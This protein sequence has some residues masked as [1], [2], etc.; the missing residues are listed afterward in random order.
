MPAQDVSVSATFEEEGPS[1]DAITWVKSE[2]SQDH[3]SD[4][5]LTVSGPIDTAS[6]HDE[7]KEYTIKTNTNPMIV[8][9][10]K[11]L[12]KIDKGHLVSIGLNTSIASNAYDDR[13]NQKRWANTQIGVGTLTGDTWTAESTFDNIKSL[14][15]E[16]VTAGAWTSNATPDTAKAKEHGDFQDN[17]LID[18]TKQVKENE[19]D[20]LSL[21]IVTLTGREQIVKN[22]PTL[23]IVTGQKVDFTVKSSAEDATPIEGA[24]IEIKTKDNP[25]TVATLTTAGGGN[26]STA[27][28]AGS[29]TYTV[30]S[31][32]YAIKKD[33]VLEIDSTDKTEEVELD[34]NQA[35]SVTIAPASGIT[36]GKGG[37]QKFTATVKDQDERDLSGAEL[38][39]T[40][41]RADE[42][43]EDVKITPDGDYTAT[44]AVEES[45]THDPDGEY[46]VTATVT[47]TEDVSGTATF[48]VNTKEPATVKVKYTSSDSKVTKAEETI[49][50]LFAGDEFT[51]DKKYY[52]A[53][54]KVSNEDGT[55]SV[56]KFNPEEQN[57][58]TI[59]ELSAG[60]NE[61]TLTYILDSKQYY[62][63]EDYEDA[64]TATL[65]TDKQ[66]L[67]TSIVD[68]EKLNSKVQLFTSTD[69]AANERGHAVF[70]FS[71][72]I[73]NEKVV[74]EYDMLFTSAD[75]KVTL[76]DLT[77]RA[78]SGKT[79]SQG[80]TTW[81]QA[82]YLTDGAIFE[83]G[84]YRDGRQSSSDLKS[85]WFEINTAAP[86]P[87][88]RQT[89]WLHVKATIDTTEKKVEYSI[90]KT[91]D[92]DKTE[93]YGTVKDNDSTPSNYMITGEKEATKFD[94]I[95]V[96]TVS[97]SAKF[98][99]DNLM[100][101][102]AD[103]E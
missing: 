97:N 51:L 74:V 85:G 17:F 49:S 73:Q 70:E 30:T 72:A 35:K 60:D 42:E 47:E 56:Y 101:Y 3:H 29:Y 15:P 52:S 14:L 83:T 26:A 78:D 50:G 58:L 45:P 11:G 46:T 2:D 90:Y 99:L 53:A 28:T 100:V 88:A 81:Q 41:K 98:S 93:L 67:A 94:Q 8:A 89:D 65:F 12:S 80:E 59:S 36:I 18:I 62:I 25:K 7:G 13:D 75:A 77:L 95:D 103:A 86:T 24:V 87:A 5:L 68:D 63:Y 33:G 38:T 23:Q 79:V 4:E 6:S 57:K 22:P 40:V 19:D 21:V 82:T 44:V 76:G 96:F 55:I 31:S 10:L 16:K 1:L 9:K 37:S 48:T 34:P 102:K 27:L 71:K 84:F 91:T 64:D 43:N 92:G 39:W 32:D 69:R 54:V 61:I 20:I 66:R